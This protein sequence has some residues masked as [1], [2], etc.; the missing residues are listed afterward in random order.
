MCA[1]AEPGPVAFVH[2]NVIPMDREQVLTDQTVVIEHGVVSAIGRDIQIPPG[3]QVIDGH[4]KYLSPG[5][6]DMHSHSDT[7]EDMNVY[8]A[9]GVTT[10][11]NLGG[12][13]SDFVDQLVPLLNRGERPGPHVYAALRIDGT[14]RYGQLVVKT[15]DEARWAVRLAKVNGYSF[16]KFYTE[17]SPSAFQA[18]ARE[19][20]KLGMGMAGHHLE[21]VPLEQE[22]K[23]GNF[24][25]A[26]LEEIIYGLFK[27]PDSDPL[28]APPPSTITDAVSLL[29]RNHAFV[30]ADLITFETISEQWGRP[31][32]AARYLASPQTRFVPFKWR[33]DWRREDYDKRKG[34]LSARVQFVR[35]LAK[36]L[37][38]AGVPIIS[39]TDAP[40]V[41]GIVPGFSLHD[42][43]DRLVAA[44]LTPFEALATATRTAGD[45]VEQSIAETPPFGKVQPG[46]RADLVLSDGNPLDTLKTLREPEGVMSH[47]HWYAR[48]D[49]QQMLASVASDYS[50]A[51]APSH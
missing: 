45:V 14:P 5:L 32:V 9:N 8:L 29:K 51:A 30:V 22:V 23:G 33:M 11:V 37:N 38:G 10:I 49:L 15:P 31:E 36:A 34:S 12:A 6:A 16:M 18:A 27:A 1:G 4:G 24:I 19:A 46:Y 25:V 35:Q 39:G 28:A 44:G 17:L 3:A 42:N 47:G 40:T 7:R 41:P 13:S 21:A 2:V 26:H 48:S 43:L 20:R 50:A